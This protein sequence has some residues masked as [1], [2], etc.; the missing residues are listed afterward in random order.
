[1]R[2]NYRT[3]TLSFAYAAALLLA[4][5]AHAQT[6][7]VINLTSNRTSSNGSYQPTL[8]WSTSP[9]A[10]SCQASGGWS[11]TKAASGT[12]VI[13][14]INATTS[15]TLTCS[16]SGSGG[17]SATIRWNRPTTNTDGSPLNDLARYRIVYGTSAGAMNRSTVI[18]D[19]SRTSATISSLTNGTWYFAVR[20]INAANVES[21]NSNTASKSVSASSGSKAKTV[22]VSIPAP[23]AGR[24]RTIATNV[25][26][27]ERRSDGVWIRRAVV[28]TIALGKPC[29]TTFRAGANHFVVNRSD[30]RL[31]STPRSSQLV[32]NCAPR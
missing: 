6:T 5:A 8:T 17:G 1:M 20:A 23:P 3:K 12:Q 22:T 2:Q 29:S 25:W 13:A 19:P 30:T 18:D 31:I 4:G 28:G 11:G 10:T 14:T 21:A 9:A 24:L 7:G 27:V 16:W 15:F 32:V 26:D